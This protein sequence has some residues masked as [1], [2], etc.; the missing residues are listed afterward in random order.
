MT[1]EEAL[2]VIQGTRSFIGTSYAH[3]VVL[4]GKFKPEE[5]GGRPL[6]DEESSSRPMR[7][8]GKSRKAFTSEAMCQV[9]RTVAYRPGRICKQCATTKNCFLVLG[10]TPQA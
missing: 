6:R 1:M 2:K 5:L 7:L 8:P 3:E 10:S 9:R 4:D